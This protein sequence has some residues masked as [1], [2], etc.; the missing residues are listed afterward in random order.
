MSAR[1]SETLS[2]R[3]FCIH[4]AGVFLLA[5]AAIFG[6]TRPDA[7]AREL[8]GQV[9]GERLAACKEAA[10]DDYG[11]LPDPPE[12]EDDEEEDD[13]DEEDVGP[14]W[15]TRAG[16][17]VFPSLEITTGNQSTVIGGP[18]GKT[19]GPARKQTFSSLLSTSVGLTHVNHNWAGGLVTTILI[20]GSR[21]PAISQASFH[22][23]HFG[24]GLMPSRFDVWG[25]DEFSFRAIAPSQSP[26]LASI[27]PWR[28]DTSLFVLSAEDPSFRRITVTG[29]GPDRAPDL[30]ARWAG[31]IGSFDLT[32]SAATHETVL[33]KG[34]ALRGYAGLASV[35][36]NTPAIGNGSYVIAQ[37]SVADKALGYLGIHT[38]NNAFGFNLPGALNAATA[39]A[40][41][42]V[43]GALVGYW[44]YRNEL[45]YAAYLT[46]TRL[47]LPG[48]AGG[49]VLSWRTA[50]NAKWT[51]IEGLSLA[52]EAGYARVATDVPF[53][54]SGNAKTLL[55]TVTRTAM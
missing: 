9:R 1:P 41:K 45:A 43:A 4:A 33:S 17:C 6:G 22:T 11:T 12:D 37:A 34:G 40:G 39:E 16:E 51:P 53:V 29:Y 38:A 20:E 42:G 31:R 10:P 14:G 25:G 50:I 46:G 19:L 26:M 35:R 24:F 54:P 5:L 8:P 27:A 52:V 18:L 36:M 3:P 2:T 44:Q 7:L 48:L 15:S 28:S 13:S 21:D 23:R 55:L 49:K 32:L 47:T 30:V